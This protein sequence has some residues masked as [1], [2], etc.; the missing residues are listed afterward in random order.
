M[1]RVS[2][3]HGALGLVLMA[4]AAAAQGACPQGLGA[5]DAAWGTPQ[6]GGVTDCCS[7]NYDQR[8][9]C[10]WPSEQGTWL[11]YAWTWLLPLLPVTSACRPPRIDAR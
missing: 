9:V 4:A 7:W 2:L 1:A 11:R 8:A 3:M 5:C 10:S 6:T